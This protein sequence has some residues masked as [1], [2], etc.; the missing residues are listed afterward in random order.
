[1]SLMR[2]TLIVAAA[3]CLSRVLGFVRDVLLAS[4]LGAGPVADAF[5][6]AFRVPNAVRRILSE[7]ALNAGFVP[8]YARLRSE[9]G[10]E[11]A[12]R[13]AGQAFSATALALLAVTAVVELGA[14]LV[15][16]LVAAGTA[17][18]PAVH[19]LAAFFV[20]ASF[21][22]VA[23][24]SLASLVSALLN[25][26]GRITV[27]SLAPVL[28]NLVVVA[29]LG[30]LSL[31][32]EI[33]PQWQAAAIAVA[34]TVGGAL[35]LAWVVLAARR[36]GNI[37]FSAPRLSPELKRLFAAGVPAMAASG[38]AQ[39]IILAGSQVASFVPAALSWVYY[40][41]RLFQLPLGLVGAAVGIVLL[42]EVAAR[43]ATGDRSSVVDAQNRALE[44]GLL[45]AC[46]AAVALAMLSRP[47]IA[48]LFE[49]GAFGPEDTAGTAAVL[50]GVAAGLPFAAVGKVL[51]QTF[52]GGHDVRTP[53]L[54]GVVGVVV[55][56]AA[57]AL[58]AQALGPLG[59]GLG[60]ASGFAAHA[61]SLVIA[62]RSARLWSIDRSLAGRVTGSIAAATAMGLGLAGTGLM[63]DPPLSKSIE[64]VRLLA[65]CIGGFALYALVAWA[66]GAI[67]RRDL[68]LFAKKP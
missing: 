6:A 63:L 19:E 49:R 65:L 32:P 34:T 59:I 41:E 1:M 52:F 36:L 61:A 43:H 27:A 38:A 16:L 66:V 11:A 68:D 39:L 8:I 53:L 37:R 47:M 44:A 40:A 35:H 56:L 12:G 30:A 10:S 33:S 3:S 55:A 58:L 67:G 45:L 15:V 7:G 4:A 57:T 26:E 29:T 62:L 54:A 48:V 2:S 14:G 9:R 60:I 24:A 46:P 18:H 21:P 5:L 13:F 22:F 64:T 17:E 42:P 31:F 25:A 20:R 23:T 28:V 51:T 50:A